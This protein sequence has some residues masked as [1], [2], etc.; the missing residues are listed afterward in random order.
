MSVLTTS[1]HHTEILIAIVQ[2]AY[3]KLEEIL[4]QWHV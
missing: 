4:D 2:C 3:N 1:P